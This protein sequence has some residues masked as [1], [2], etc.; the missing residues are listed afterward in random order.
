LKLNHAPTFPN[1]ADPE[2]RRMYLVDTT[3]GSEDEV[4][5]KIRERY[6]TIIKYAE[7]VAARRLC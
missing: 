5:R 6:P 1:D 3:V 4:I 2:L 7:R